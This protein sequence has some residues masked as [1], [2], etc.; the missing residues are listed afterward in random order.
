V[1]ASARAQSSTVHQTY[2]LITPARDEERNL[3]RLAAS[4]L[5]QT[6]QPLAWVVVDDGSTD[7]TAALVDELALAHDWIS[8]VSG[9]SG[10]GALVEGRLSGRDVAAFNTGLAALPSTPEIV[11]KLDA[12][13]SLLPDFFELLLGEFEQDP[14]L[15]IAGGACFELE[16]GGWRE[17]WV[18]GDHVRGA[19]RAYRWDCLRDVQPLEPRL[20]WD[21]IDEVRAALLGWR[22]RS[23]RSLPFFHY[24]RMGERDGVRR[25]FRDQG[26]TAHYMGYRPSYLLARALFG[27][28]RTPAAAAMLGGYLRAAWSGEPSLEDSAV[29]AHIRQRQR[30]RELPRRA[31]EA[32]GRRKEPGSA[33]EPG[34]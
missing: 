32:L 13:V 21:G 26:A 18:T 17:R 20:G 11:L 30:L 10:D 15:G 28:R 9:S 34:S 5:A 24:R 1:A 23:F 22:T 33:L 3:R 16:D 2:A 12:D 7:G 19:T 27:M 8:L 4:L 6:V 29:R 14:R 31:F 25:S